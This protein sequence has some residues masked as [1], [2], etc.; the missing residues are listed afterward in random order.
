MADVSVLH[1]TGSPT[2]ESG[3]SS[4]LASP[5]AQRLHGSRWKDPRLWIGVVLVLASVVVGARLLA[6]ADDTVSVWA[7]SDDLAAGSAVD[8]GDVSVVDVHF[9]SSAAAERYVS[10][11]DPLPSGMHLTR[12]VGAGELLATSALSADPDSAPAQLP[13]AVAPAGMP[14]DLAAGDRADLWAV[15]TDDNPA[16]PTMV[17]DG[18]TVVSVSTAGPGGVGSQ[19]QVLVTIPTT[20]DIAR[21]LAALRGADVVLIRTDS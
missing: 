21:V 1:R 18:V 3:G 6:A 13:L 19:R 7:L 8:A 12:D 11:D 4:E 14:S 20:A 9:D 10:A 2:T 5:P 15:P 17:L 16:A